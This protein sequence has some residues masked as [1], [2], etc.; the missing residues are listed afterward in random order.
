[1]Y[2]KTTTK[3]VKAGLSNRTDNFNGT[4]KIIICLE[5]FITLGPKVYSSTVNVSQHEH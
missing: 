5:I 2:D 3:P 4:H 1:M